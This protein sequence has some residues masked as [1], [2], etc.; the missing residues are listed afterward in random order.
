[1]DPRDRKI[2]NCIHGL[3]HEVVERLELLESRTVS[4]EEYRKALACPQC[5]HAMARVEVQE[6]S[7]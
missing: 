7:P 2:I 3:L 1:M 5:G 4:L 6:E